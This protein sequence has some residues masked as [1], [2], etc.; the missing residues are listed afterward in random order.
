MMRWSKRHIATCVLT[1]IFWMAQG[2]NVASAQGTASLSGSVVDAVTGQPL[3]GASIFLGHTSRGA[4]TGPDGTYQIVQ[5]PPGSFELVASMVGYAPQV[6]QVTVEA[7][8]NINADFRL[9]PT[10]YEIDSV[11]VVGERSRQWERNLRRFIELFVGTSSNAKETRILNPNVLRFQN[12]GREFVAESVEPLLIENEALGYR[13]TFILADFR[14]EREDVTF[15]G[16]P[17]FEEMEAR[18]ERET[19]RWK[20]NREKTYL[21]SFRHLLRAL[22]SDR[23]EEE[24]FIVREVRRPGAIGSPLYLRANEIVART[25]R[26]YEFT[27]AFDQSLHVTYTEEPEEGRRSFW[28]SLWRDDP[29]SMQMSWLTSTV[30]QL[31]LYEL[32]YVFPSTSIVLSGS[33]G[34]ERIADQLPHEYAPDNQGAREPEDREPVEWITDTVISRPSA[35]YAW[36]QPLIEEEDWGEIIRQTSTILEQDSGDL[37]ALYYRAVARRE[38]GVIRTLFGGDQWARSTDDFEAILA[39]D[40]S[41]QDVLYQYALLKRYAWRNIDALE[42]GNAQVFEKPESRLLRFALLD[43]YRHAAQF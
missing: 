21:G 16:Y 13:L 29:P 4:V 25:S 42:I 36:V 38:A 1:L 24:G 9:Q 31:S 10:V 27:F 11:V 40:S 15:W 20:E 19:L 35:P 18:S 3:N 32:G 23:L 30:P 43:L 5:V 6:L 17:Y 12:R 28:R 26:P 8:A 2:W 34:Q 39:S 14:A 41:Y 7:V 22:A 37:E 33:M